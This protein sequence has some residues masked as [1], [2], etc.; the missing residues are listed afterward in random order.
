MARCDIALL[1]DEE[2]GEHRPSGVFV[3]DP[4]DVEEKVA[5]T[6]RRHYRRVEIVPFLASV[7]ETIERLRRLKPRVIFNLTEWVDGDRT[8][9]AAV[10][11]LL[12]MMQFRYTGTG[13]DGLRLARDK[14]LASRIVAGLGFSVPR[15][16][17]IDGPTS[18]LRDGV[19]FPLVIKPRFGDGSDGI[20]T[21]S[22]VRNVHELRTRA[23][24]AASRGPALCEEY[25]PGR[26]VYVGLLGNEPA[27][28]PPVELMVKSRDRAA[29]RIAT[30]R[31]KSDPRYRRKWGIHYRRARLGPAA[32][33]ALAAASRHI[34]HALKLRDYARIDFR[35]TDEGRV[36]F[37]EANPNPDLDP[38]ALN[39]SGC[40]SGV[41][42]GKLL[43]TIVE[44][45]RRR[46]K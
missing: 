20:S 33:K 44:S 18:R 30:Y 10:A 35:M 42:Y 27:V 21:R 24:L 29:P 43:E 11:G 15:S 3:P 13:P 39:R 34:F 1:V 37:I 12:D 16:F 22:I 4:N 41:P 5:R 23:R 31:L 36:Y 40:F 8:L 9:D 32:L 25:I 28:L 17:A 7:V 45:A 26:D 46:Q 2:T 19:S 6:L 14:A 38:H